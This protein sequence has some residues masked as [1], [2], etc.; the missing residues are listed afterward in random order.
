MILLN[1]FDQKK[2]DNEVC[3]FVFT[4]WIFSY[5]NAIPE[6]VVLR[7]CFW[8]PAKNVLMG[9]ENKLQNRI[10]HVFAC[11]CFY[12]FLVVFSWGEVCWWKTHFTKVSCY[13]LLLFSI[14]W[15]WHLIKIIL[16][17][18]FYMALWVIV[19]VNVKASFIFY[20]PDSLHDLAKLRVVGCNYPAPDTVCFLFLDK[21]YFFFSYKYVICRCVL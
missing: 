15:T 16:F 7:M 18:F 21:S 13:S 11:S 1:L 19:Q 3:R 4:F 12:S 20:R 6:D 8:K 17:F 9:R 5:F 2:K 14:M 10:P